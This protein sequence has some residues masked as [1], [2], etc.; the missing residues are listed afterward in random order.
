MTGIFVGD[1]LIGVLGGSFDPVHR[2]HIQT[3]LELLQRFP[4]AEIRLVPA[5]RS[6]LKEA[7]TAFSHRVAMLRLAAHQAPGLV[8]DDMEGQRPPPSYTVDTLKGLRQRMAPTQPLVFI[9]GEDALTGLMDWKDWQRLTDFAHL[10]VVHRPGPR[11]PLP[12]DLATWIN[13]R[14][15][16]VDALSLCSQGKIAFAD[17]TPRPISA[18]AV[19]KALFQGNDDLTCWLDQD[20]ANYIEQH[21]LYQMPTQTPAGDIPAQ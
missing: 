5:A 8:I 20:V 12:A 17:T 13:A 4:F 1:K 9:L 15:V 21:H 11:L 10:L 18:T 3:A 14:T 19:R 6:P 16:N 7:G 2:G